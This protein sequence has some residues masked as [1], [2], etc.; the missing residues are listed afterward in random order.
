LMA[1]SSIYIMRV[2]CPE[3]K[4]DRKA[5]RRFEVLLPIAC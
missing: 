3:E 5:E 2:S 4:S 1:S